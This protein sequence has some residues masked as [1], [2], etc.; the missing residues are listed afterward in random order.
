MKTLSILTAKSFTTEAQRHRE[1]LKTIKYGFNIEINVKE[2]KCLFSQF[3]KLI[4]S[5]PLCLCGEMFVVF[6]KKYA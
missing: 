3:L 6:N 2:V 4:F 5:V 1:D